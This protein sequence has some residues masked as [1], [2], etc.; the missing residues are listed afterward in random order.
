MTAVITPNK[1]ERLQRVFALTQTRDTHSDEV[2]VLNN[3]SWEQF[4][5]LLELLPDQRGTLL[6]YLEGELELMAPSHNHELV[7]ERFGTLLE[8]YF[9][10][11]DIDYIALG[12]KTL[13]K[14]SVKRGIEPDKCFFF[15]E[16]QEFPDLAIEVI[17]TSGG[18]DL[19]EV[20]KEFG[21]QEVWF[22]EKGKISIFALNDSVYIEVEQSILLADLKKKVLEA[23]LTAAGTS[24]TIRKQFKKSIS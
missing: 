14:E 20:Y 17:I 16:N 23:F 5:G 18:I 6:R 13:K 9:V 24:L 19:L 10:E 21:V 15:S 8:C 7:V 4:N 22:W 12:S 11:K 2:F 3:V 1:V